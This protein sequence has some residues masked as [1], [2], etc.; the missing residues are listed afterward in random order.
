MAYLKCIYPRR[1]GSMRRPIPLLLLASAAACAGPRAFSRST[2][3]P[4]PDVFAC[5]HDQLERR[6]YELVLVDSVGGLLQ[7]HREVTGIREAARRGAAA[8]TGVITGGLAGGSFRRYEE[9]TV[10]LRTR[11]YPETNMV[12]ATAGLLTITED[13]P[14]REGATDAGKRDARELV[15]ACAPQ[16]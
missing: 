5:A 6:D 9:L 2:V 12:E 8:A 10:F 13:A 16:E 1:Q 4:L 3:L 7:G 15:E 11:R 14:K